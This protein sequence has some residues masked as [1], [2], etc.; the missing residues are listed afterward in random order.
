MEAAINTNP[1]A[2]DDWTSYIFPSPSRASSASPIQ[3]TCLEFYQVPHTATTLLLQATPGAFSVYDTSTMEAIGRKHSTEGDAVRMARFIDAGSGRLQ[4]VLLV[5]LR[6]SVYSLEEERILHDIS[7]PSPVADILDVQVNTSVVAVLTHH[8]VRLLNRS[9]NYAVLRT[10]TITSDA[11]A[12]GTRWLAYPSLHT[13]AATVATPTKDDYS[14]TDIAQGVAS[15][16]YYLSKVARRASA[17]SDTGHIDV[18]DC[19]SQARIASFV[20]HASAITSLA[21]NPS[22]M[23]VISSSDK[24][25]TLHVHRVQDNALLYRLHRGI[26]HARIRHITTSMDSKWIAITTSRG[27]THIYAIRPEGGAIGGHTHH[28]VD[29]NNTTHLSVAKAS[30][31]DENQA[32]AFQVGASTRALTE[33]LQP[34]ARLRHSTED[35]GLVSCQWDRQLLFVASC[36]TLKALSVQPRSTL[37]DVPKPWLVLSLH[38]EVAKQRELDPH[39]PSRRPYAPQLIQHPTSSVEIVVHPQL[40]LPIW[41]HPKVTFRAL[42]WGK[43]RLL[44]VKRLGPV[45]LATDDVVLEQLTQGVSPVFDGTPS[46]DEPFV[47]LFDLSASISHAVSSSLSIRPVQAHPPSKST[48]PDAPSTLQDAYF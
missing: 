45:P 9:A 4:N 17:D 26:T 24:G 1:G 48:Q 35:G 20:A 44:N 43:L 7:F 41:L 27:T 8:T 28:A 23:L 40:D 13:E 21:F 46:K 11:M 5:T 31:A 22:G 29:L 30:I 16:L 19:V 2:L 12:L 37:V 38:L 39:Q 18:Q 3:V 47:P 6:L 34:L 33:T 15:G 14:L 32:K 25:Q 10:I 36:G 42:S